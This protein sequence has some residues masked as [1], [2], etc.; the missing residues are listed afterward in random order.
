MKIEV[1]GPGCPRCGATAENVAQAL[2]DL[3]LEDAIEKITDINA[4]IDRGVLQSPALII[5]GAIVVQGKIPTV[6]QVKQFIAK[7]NNP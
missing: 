1:A 2:K 5:N 7:A 4:M 3:G 6:E